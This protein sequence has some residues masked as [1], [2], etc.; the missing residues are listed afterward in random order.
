MSTEFVPRAEFEMFCQQQR[1][2]SQRI[3][4]SLA[5]INEKIDGMTQG[6]N[7]RV[8]WE[9]HDRHRRECNEEFHK[10]RGRPSWAIVGMFGLMSSTIAGLIILIVANV[11]H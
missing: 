10:L 6:M 3:E 8:T 7:A 5:V 1:E 2:S 4:A 9:A 11:I